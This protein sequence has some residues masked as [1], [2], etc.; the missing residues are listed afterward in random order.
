VNPGKY[1]LRVNVGFLTNQSIGAYRDIAFDY[2]RLDLDQ[3]FSVKDFS[4]TARLGRTQQG[5]LV[6]AV[7]RG[8]LQLECVRCLAELEQR[9][10]ASFDELY[11]FKFKGVSESGLIVPDDA[12]IN[13]APLVREYFLL[14]VPISPVCKPDCRGL[15]PVCGA[16]LNTE[17]CEH[18]VTVLTE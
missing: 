17:P 5:I 10:E 12:N 11:A 1:P 13:L 2:P 4:G 3:D 18:H 15:C 16:D 8:D 14:E 6:Q 9:I 7:F